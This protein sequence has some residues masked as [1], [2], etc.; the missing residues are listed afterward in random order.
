[1]DDGM[2]SGIGAGGGD[3]GSHDGPVPNPV[4]LVAPPLDDAGQVY[5]ATRSIID[6]VDSSG[7]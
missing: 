7:G 5:A 2:V 4:G 3:R 6:R 1:M